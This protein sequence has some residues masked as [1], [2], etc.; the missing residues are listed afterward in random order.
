MWHKTF[1]YQSQIWCIGFSLF[2]VTFER[3]H[4]IQGWELTF[5]TT[6]IKWKNCCDAVR[7]HLEAQSCYI[8]A[9]TADFPDWEE[10]RTNLQEYCASILTFWLHN[11]QLELVETFSWDNSDY[12]L[13]NFK[14]W[15][16][17]LHGKFFIEI[18]FPS[19]WYDI[20]YLTW[21]IPPVSQPLIRI[22]T[23][24]IVPI[25]LPFWC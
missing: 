23:H 22:D 1:I 25:I 19:L 11:R 5:Y 16:K 17:K 15:N 2:I 8:C 6:S 3:E 24:P 9:L 10:L 7:K 4:D 18:L 13:I 12:L 20:S 21:I 14:T